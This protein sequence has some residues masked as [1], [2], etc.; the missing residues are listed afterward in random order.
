MRELLSRSCSIDFACR[1][2]QT[3]NTARTTHAATVSEDGRVGM[4][5]YYSVRRRNVRA[6]RAA[7]TELTY[8]KLRTALA[9]SSCTS[10]TVYSFVIC[11]RSLTRLLRLSSF[12]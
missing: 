6:E 10:K 2:I 8:A 5:A 4:C 3:V 11:N 9:S 7:R 12:N 1:V